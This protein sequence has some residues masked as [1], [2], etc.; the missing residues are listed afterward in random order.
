MVNIEFRL[1][2][3]FLG[4][5]FG[6]VKV[7]TNHENRQLLGEFVSIQGQVGHSAEMKSD[8]PYSTP[9]ERGAY[10]VLAELEKNK[11]LWRR[12][13]WITAILSVTIPILTTALSILGMRQAFKAV[14][15][16]GIGNPEALAAH[17]SELLIATAAG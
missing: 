1:R 4:R 14:G 6:W 7:L 10:P 2:P 11:R 12:M 3:V 16:S 13:I 17:I 9:K 15:S 8:S 5:F